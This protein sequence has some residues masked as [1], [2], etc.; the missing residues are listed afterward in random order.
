MLLLAGSLVAFGAM[1]GCA[2]E[3]EPT[4]SA[5]ETTTGTTT[6]DTSATTDGNAGATT[7]ETD[8][9]PPAQDTTYKAPAVKD[10]EEVGVIDTEKGQIIV[11][12]FPD[13][14]P[15]HVERFKMLANKHFWDGIR[16]HRC[17]A[18]MMIQ[19]G[20]PKT[21]DLSKAAEWGTGG[22]EENGKEV[23]LKAEFNDTPH[24]RGIL[25]AARTSDP[26]TASSQFFLMHQAYPSLDHQYT[27][28]GQIVKGIEVVD[29]IVKTGDP[30][31]NGA[32]VPTEAVV[33]KTIRI[34]KW[35][36]K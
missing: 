36:V 2:K 20:D 33:V 27:V 35:P 4:G 19:G 13:K 34:A 7:G 23:T 31:D 8:P 9:T 10:G 26:D 30:N 18:G 6:G 28:Y 3:P 22:Y 21:K 16:F 24:T 14:A 17:I 11:K 5:P 12:F 25:S 32:V 29:E 15:K 1:F